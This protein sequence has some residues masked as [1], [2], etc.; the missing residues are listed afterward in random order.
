M[1]NKFCLT[2]SEAV[3]PLLWEAKAFDFD[4]G[5]IKKPGVQGRDQ[6]SDVADEAVDEDDD[7]HG[8]PQL[9]ILLLLLLLITISGFTCG[10]SIGS[11]FAV[12]LFSPLMLPSPEVLEHL[13]QILLHAVR[14]GVP[15]RLFYFV[16]I[17]IKSLGKI[18]SAYTE[19]AAQCNQ[20][21]RKP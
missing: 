6:M 3:R 14:H 18:Y 8:E 15:S 11:L 9:F 13:E 7:G 2:A 17:E 10:F 5:E 20:N 1:L 12:T 21:P 16:F 19:L 4:E